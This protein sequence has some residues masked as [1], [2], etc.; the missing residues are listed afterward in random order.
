MKSGSWA[1]FQSALPNEARQGGERDDDVLRTSTGAE[2]L[3]VFWYDEDRNTAGMLVKDSNG[4]TWAGEYS[5]S[6]MPRYF[7][8]DVKA[9]AQVVVSGGSAQWMAR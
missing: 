9:R 4:T 2:I 1:S 5:H 6:E 8:D 3:E 7:L